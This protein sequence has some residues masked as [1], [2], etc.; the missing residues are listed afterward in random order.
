MVQ[1]SFFDEVIAQCMMGTNIYLVL[2]YS[3]VGREIP[4]VG[5]SFAAA[6]ADNDGFTV[7]RRRRK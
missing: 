1:K 5:A 3:N 7:R 2:R 6:K 4:M